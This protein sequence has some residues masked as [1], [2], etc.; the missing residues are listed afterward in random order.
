MWLDHPDK[1]SERSPTD[2]KPP[3]IPAWLTQH[4]KHVIL[5]SLI[6]KP[7]VIS[8]GFLKTVCYLSSHGKTEMQEEP[9]KHW[10]ELRGDSQHV[11]VHSTSSRIKSTEVCVGY[12]GQGTLGTWVPAPKSP[13]G[14]SL[15]LPV[16]MYPGRQQVALVV[17]TSNLI[18]RLRLNSRFWALKLLPAF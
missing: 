4:H 11:R 15:Q 9:G 13:L 12:N 2:G 17:G 6:W 5:P 16:S 14:I 18:N 1:R 8:S 3:P 10:K 7:N